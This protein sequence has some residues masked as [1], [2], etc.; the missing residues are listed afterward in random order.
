MS[1]SAN[2]VLCGGTGLA[3]AALG[4]RLIRANETKPGETS[5]VGPLSP[6]TLGYS[7]GWIALFFGLLMTAMIAPMMYLRG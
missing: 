6:R 7:G 5:F 1:G 4:V 3:L 2:A